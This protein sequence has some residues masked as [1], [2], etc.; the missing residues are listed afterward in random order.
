LK[1]EK[2]RCIKETCQEHK[3]TKLSP[4]DVTRQKSSTKMSQYWKKSMMNSP[5]E[6]YIGNSKQMLQRKT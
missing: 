4:K 3:K 1:Q 2:H 5:E 6:P